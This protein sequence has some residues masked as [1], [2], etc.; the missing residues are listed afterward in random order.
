MLKCKILIQAEHG[1]SDMVKKLNMHCIIYHLLN[2][3]TRRRYKEEQIGK[4]FNIIMTIYLCMFMYVY[5]CNYTYCIC[6]AA[7]LSLM[8]LSCLVSL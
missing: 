2:F 5:V 4:M 1:Q 7:K 6:K 8:R 3:E